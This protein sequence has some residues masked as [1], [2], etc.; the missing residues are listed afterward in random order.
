VNGPK[1][2]ANNKVD[3]FIQSLSLGQLFYFFYTIHTGGNTIRFG[4]KISQDQ[5]KFDTDFQPLCSTLEPSPLGVWIFPGRAI[6]GGGFLLAT[7][8][9]HVFL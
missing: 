1:I 9:G 2:G 4:F 6:C 5:G 8:F 7:I 3:K